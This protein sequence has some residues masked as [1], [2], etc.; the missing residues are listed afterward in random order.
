MLLACGLELIVAA[1]VTALIVGALGGAT[2]ATLAAR[3]ED[4]IKAEGA[5][6][7]PCSDDS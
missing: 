6:E 2:A 5:K 4:E 3:A 7:V 1:K